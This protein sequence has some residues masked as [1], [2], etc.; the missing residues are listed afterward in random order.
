MDRQ[1]KKI[2]RLY[3]LS[4]DARDVYSLPFTRRGEMYLYV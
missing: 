4:R 3:M 2:N 1:V